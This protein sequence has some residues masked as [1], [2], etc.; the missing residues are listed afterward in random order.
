M[1]HSEILLILLFDKTRVC[2]VG[3]LLIL[4][5]DKR[6]S[7]KNLTYSAKPINLNLI[8]FMVEFYLF[9]FLIRQTFFMLNFTDSSDS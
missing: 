9:K 8:F 1:F 4:V 2:H 5:R 6:I 3:N 7:F